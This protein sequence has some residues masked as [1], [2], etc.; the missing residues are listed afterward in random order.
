MGQVQSKHCT[1]CKRCFTTSGNV[2]PVCGGDLD[3]D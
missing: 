3:D 2:C 1:S